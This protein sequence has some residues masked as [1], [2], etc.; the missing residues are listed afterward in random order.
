MPTF[1]ILLAAGRSERFGEDKLA[2]NL[3]GKPVWQWSLQALLESVDHVGVVCNPVSRAWFEPFQER[4]AFLVEGG[5]NRQDSVAQGLASIP[6]GTDVRVLI[7][8]AARPLVSSRLIRSL[9]EALD[10]HRAA[11]PVLPVTDT[12]RQR[13]SGQIVDR[14]ALWAMQTPQAGY[15]SEFLKALSSTDAQFTDD[16]ALL[17]TLGI[18]PAYIP[19]EARNLKITTQEDMSRLSSFLPDE[20]RVGLGY[21]VHAFSTDPDRPMWLGGVEFDDRP[22]LDGHS[23]ADALVHAVVD[24]L[25]GAISAGDIGML[26]PNTDP[27]W[28][29]CPSLRF[30]S[31][32]ADLLRSETWDIVNVDCSV[33]AERPKI[34]PRR[35]EICAA[36]ANAMGID[37]SRVSVK[38]TTNERLGAIGRGEGVAAFATATVRRAKH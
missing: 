23:D 24:A 5:A 13:E 32:T 26:Y 20:I 34:L 31:E 36:L 7:H 16:I 29:N 25:L 10:T 28:K 9:I 22:G 1:G 18:Q 3:G 15:L 33:I 35:V 8:D 37:P 12:L 38:A 14:D 2:Q 27:R 4:L 19:G 17:Q 21:D 30:L 11:V 6:P